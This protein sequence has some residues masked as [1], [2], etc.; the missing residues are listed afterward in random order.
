MALQQV[1]DSALVQRLTEV[2]RKTGF[3]A[4][5]LAELQESTGLKK[6]SLYHRFP[7]GKT[8]MAE[9]VLDNTLRLFA[10][11]ILAPADDLSIELSERIAQIGANL[12]DFYDA[13][14][15]S[16]LLESLS[17]GN[18]PPGLSGKLHTMMNAWIGSFA[19]LS[20]S[21]GLSQADALKR[22]SN[23][24]AL[25]EGALVVSRVTGD[26]TV[27]QRAI[28]ELEQHLTAQL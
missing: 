24:V 7:E 18:V 19:L 5:S 4:A 11:E 28:G 26:N 22:S 1:P 13:G 8:Q 23:T 3:T 15:L 27:F 10:E 17:I 6:S 12:S 2:F 9:A 20:Q 16:C 14:L 25:I 21:S